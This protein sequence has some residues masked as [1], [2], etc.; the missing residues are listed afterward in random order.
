[1]LTKNLV[2]R[3]EL[4]DPDGVYESIRNHVTKSLKDTEGLTEEE[5]NSLTEERHEML[6]EI[7]QEWVTYGEYVTVEINLETKETKVCRNGN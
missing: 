5:V 4:K 7:L 6:S 2:I 3:L 1:M